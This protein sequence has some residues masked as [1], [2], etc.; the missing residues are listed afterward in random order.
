M[1]AAI[2]VETANADVGSVCQ[3]GIAEFGDD[4]FANGW[5]SL[6]DPEDFFDSM[7]VSIHG[8]DEETV[9][10]AP[11]FVEL[12]SEVSARLQGK[13]VVCHTAFDRLAL[14]R[15]CERCAVSEPACTWLDS[16]R[17]ARRIWRQFAQ[18]GY[19]LSNLASFLKYE[20]RHHDALEDAKAAGHIVFSALNE[21]GLA[22]EALVERARSP[23]TPDGSRIRLDGHPEGPLFGERI[24]FTGALEMP[25]R[26]AAGLAA[27]LGCD[28]LPG[29]T[30]KTTLLV[31]G[32]QDVARLAGHSKS[33]KHRRAEEL[34]TEGVPIRILRESD[35]KSLTTLETATHESTASTRSSNDRL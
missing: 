13:I 31:V 8:I 22:I 24:V 12:A 35:F 2:D 10:G 5:K 3:I 20:F 30:K 14:Q 23:L 29:V 34:I 21:S 15:A 7:N 25:R 6:V 27:Q 32:D 17:V 18:R 19:G 1:F 11:T 28:V 9:I 16:A 26:E 33:R 4:G